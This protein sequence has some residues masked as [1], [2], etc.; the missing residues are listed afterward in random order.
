MKRVLTS[1][2]I[3]LVLAAAVHAQATLTGKWQG[4][5]QNGSQIVLDLTAIETTLT[6][7]LTR[8]GEPTTITDGKVSN[9]SFTFKAKLGE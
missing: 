9:N 2:T 5:T 1:A 7:T 8:N 6:G 3:A 4:E